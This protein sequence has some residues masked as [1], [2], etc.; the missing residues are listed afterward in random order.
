MDRDPLVR[1]F[2]FGILAALVALVARTGESG[3][4][5][6]GVPGASGAN[7][8]FALDSARAGS[9]ILFRIDTQTGQT[10]KLELRG[11]NDRWKPL[12]EPDED[13]TEPAGPPGP[14]AATARIPAPA[15]P[16]QRY[17]EPPPPTPPSQPGREGPEWDVPL[18]VY[19]LKDPD[20][21]VDVRIW[22]A[23]RL[24]VIDEPGSTDGLLAVLEDPEPR[25]VAAALTALKGR[26]DPRIAPALRRARGHADAGV[27]A[28]AE[29]HAE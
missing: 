22:C 18:L 9:P 4:V 27:Q 15:P 17:A 23:G 7:G 13:A 10:W 6:V 24:A 12:Y 14:R 19:A 26:S 1:I 28:A 25:I 20:Q 29:S 5:P 2:L 21:H 16:R 11:G 8:R 3:G